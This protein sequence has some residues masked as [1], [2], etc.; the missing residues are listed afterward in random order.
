[1]SFCVSI[2]SISTSKMS[3]S[4]TKGRVDLGITIP[5]RCCSCWS[6]RLTISLPQTCKPELVLLIKFL[7]NILKNKN[8]LECNAVVATK[9]ELYFEGLTYP[10]CN[11]YAN[12]NS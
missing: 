12:K 1:M 4:A 5:S 10:K 6:F 9:S 7:V 3:L 8:R 11:V 2:P